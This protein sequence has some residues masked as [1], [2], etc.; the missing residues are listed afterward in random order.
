M[1]STPGALLLY[2]TA[3]RNRG[4]DELD[5][6]YP[7]QG[8]ATMRGHIE[9]VMHLTFPRVDLGSTRP[10]YERVSA[11]DVRPWLPFAHATVEGYF[12]DGRAGNVLW[13]SAGA[14][15]GTTRGRSPQWD[16][17]RTEKMTQR[18]WFEWGHKLWP[19][20]GFDYFLAQ[21]RAP[22]EAIYTPTLFFGIDPIAPEKVQAPPAH[23][24]I[25]PQRGF[26]M[27]RAEEG[28]NHW[29]SPAPAVC[30]RLTA[31]YAHN[32]FCALHVP[33]EGRPQNLRFECIAQ[34]PDAIAVRVVGESG[35]GIDDRIL[36]CIGDQAN[37]MVTLEGDGEHFRFA[38][39]AFVRIRS[40]KVIAHGELKA[41]TLKMDAGQTLS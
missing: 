38:D 40:D 8:G 16:N 26:A 5:F 15:G 29:E 10:R 39:F 6:G 33:F 30:L 36:L 21:M 14:W 4:L 19:D 28:P 31:N 17:D 20:A 18:L 23:S 27:L 34:T 13:N 24:A 2:C 32:V 7:G 1:T 35:S 11:G 25:Y 9:S 22:D 37:Q 41:L 3:L 12:P